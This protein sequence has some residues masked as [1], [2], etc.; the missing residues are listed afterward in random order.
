MRL[1]FR[2]LMLFL[3]MFI[4]ARLNAQDV[5]TVMNNVFN[6]SPVNIPKVH[7]DVMFNKNEYDTFDNNSFT[8][9][10]KKT[11][12]HKDAEESSYKVEFLLELESE[13][14]NVLMINAINNDNKERTRVVPND[15]DTY[16]AELLDGTYDFWIIFM[17]SEVGYP[18]Q[19]NIVIFEK[20][21]VDKDMVIS[22]KPEDAN[23][24]IKFETYTINGDKCFTGRYYMDNNWN[25][26]MLEEPNTDDVYMLSYMVNKEIDTG[27]IQLS[28]SYQ[29]WEGAFQINGTETM[30]DF[31]VN[32]V[33]NRYVFSCAKIFTYEG[34]A[35]TAYFEI[36]GSKDTVI[37]N[38]P[39]DF[40]L[41]EEEFK[42]TPMA[43]ENVSG[44]CPSINYDIIDFKIELANGNGPYQYYLGHQ[45]TTTKSGLRPLLYPGISEVSDYSIYAPPIINNDGN[46]ERVYN[47]IITYNYHQYGDLAQFDCFEEYPKDGDYYY[48]PYYRNGY[49]KNEQ[50]SYPLEKKIGV[51]G[52][53]CPI[54]I[55]SLCQ[56]PYKDM[57]FSDI[58]CAYL[59]RY[60][61]WRSYDNK[62]KDMH[63]YING[64]E[65]TFDEYGFIEYS[66][67]TGTVEISII[68]ENVRVDD[69]TGKNT[70]NLF[71]D[72]D[73]DDS[74]PPTMQMLHL[75]NEDG[76][77]TDRFEQPNQ[78]TLEF[79]CGDFNMYHD[80]V[81]SDCLPLNEVTVL[82]SPYQKDNWVN[83][84]VEEVP[85]NY[86]LP[87]L[88]FFY[89]GSLKD[90]AGAAEKGWFDLKIR[91]EDEAGNWQEQ[92]VSPA[93]QIKSLVDTGISQL[94]IDNGQLTIR[95]NENV[96]D[97]MGRCIGNAPSSTD[98]G[99]RIVRKANGDFRKVVL[100]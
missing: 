42:N 58:A 74:T 61:E 47:G 35:F 19:R 84:E 100:R 93:F 88:G 86:Y 31:F 30:G 98:K 89:T 90:V 57:Y 12:L 3:F 51:F 38:K 4:A 13:D 10:I 69:M 40:V 64:E 7:M 67:P 45:P 8:T 24:H 34:K 73:K 6:E 52:N 37:V 77:I 76:I 43:D 80:G 11:Q 54:A 72:R 68:N 20:V 28:N 78:G 79:Y 27:D 53:N 16:C 85:E 60:G 97:L 65:T 56:W 75:K 50:L 21:I 33:S 55:L 18:V 25:I 14:W 83:L 36:E 62:V 26:T 2:N 23:R 82:Y 99:I 71:Y 87:A 94:T 91:L 96:Y 1:L 41:Y 63:I 44:S 17:K 15:D 49:E 32:D 70:L 29:A 9:Y 59:G 95:G 5:I 48:N 39:E 22:A 46:L 92:I 66:K 81:K